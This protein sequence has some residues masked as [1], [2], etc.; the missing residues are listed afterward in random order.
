M[1]RHIAMLRFLF[2]HKWYVLQECRRLGVPLWNAL[3]H[4]WTKCLPSEWV[5]YA[6]AYYGDDG[7]FRL[8]RTPQYLAA[9]AKHRQR[10]KHH[11]EHWLYT[12]ADGTQAAHPMPDS[13]RREMLADWFGSQ[14]A[15]QRDKPDAG[16][17]Y[18]AIVQWYTEKR[19]TIILHP[20]TR[21]WVEHQLAQIT[22]NP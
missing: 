11:W 8:Q 2:W 14:R 16:D 9:V 15:I 3:I 10:N 4:D 6:Y 13:Y 19:E 12:M 20:Q 7:Q 1:R 5:A 18:Q 22:N 17:P 21:Q